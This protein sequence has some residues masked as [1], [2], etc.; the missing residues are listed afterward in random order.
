MVFS[1][2]KDRNEYFLWEFLLSLTFDLS[3]IL[4]FVYF[5]AWVRCLKEPLMFFWME[6]MILMVHETPLYM[7]CDF[8][9]WVN[10]VKSDIGNVSLCMTHLS[11]GDTRSAVKPAYLIVLIVWLPLIN[12]QALPTIRPLKDFK[13]GA[14]FGV[15]IG[16]S[17]FSSTYYHAQ[18]HQVQGTKGN[19]HEIRCAFSSLDV[20]SKVSCDK[21]EPR[22][23]NSG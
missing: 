10:C 14:Y 1:L 5:N 7:K 16:T 6:L 19:Q 8:C 2:N 11:M 17:H 13:R 4:I 21:I 20:I 15:L 9:R 22:Q 3:H 18:E 23:N 12:S